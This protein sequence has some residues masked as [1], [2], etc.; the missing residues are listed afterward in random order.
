MMSVPVKAIVSSRS[1]VKDRR[2]VVRSSD[3]SSRGVSVCAGCD[4]A[5]GY[6]A[7]CSDDDLSK[8]DESLGF[9]VFCDSNVIW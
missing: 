8:A 9:V 2:P 5:N 3:G 1:H 7:N 6:V 4:D